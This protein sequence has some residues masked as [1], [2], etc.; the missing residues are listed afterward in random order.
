MHKMRDAIINVKLRM[1]REHRETQMS[2]GP[3][4][5]YLHIR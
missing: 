3:D 4:I 5:C 1:R 2:L